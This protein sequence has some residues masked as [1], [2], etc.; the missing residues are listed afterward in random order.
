M[1][2]QIMNLNSQTEFAPVSAFFDPNKFSID[3]VKEIL[4]ELTGEDI[5]VE[6]DGILFFNIDKQFQA[7]EDLLADSK[8]EAVDAPCTCKPREYLDEVFDFINTEF[9]KL[10]YYALQPHMVDVVFDRKAGRE[11]LHNAKA[12]CQTIFDHYLDAG[13][14][15]FSLR[16][17]NDAT[18]AT[19]ESDEKAGQ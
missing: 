2:G 9:G 3:D 5:V 8:E 13:D 4:Q 11:R 18:N 14:L 17:I 7:I 1:K 15:V 10:R 12:I 16:G 19:H 6:E